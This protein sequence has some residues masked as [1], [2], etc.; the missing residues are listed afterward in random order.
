MDNTEKK[1]S[2]Y[3]QAYVPSKERLAELVTKAKGPERSMAEFSRICKVKS[4]S[5]FSRIVNKLIDKPVSDELLIAIAKNTADSDEVTLDM[6]MRANGKVLKDDNPEYV[7]DPNDRMNIGNHRKGIKLIRDII[8][9][10]Y[11]DEGKSVMLHPDIEIDIDLYKKQPDSK[12]KL[13]FPSHFSLTVQGEET[14]LVNYIIDFTDIHGAS[15]KEFNEHKYNRFYFAENMNK[16][17]PLFLRDAWEPESLRNVKNVIVFTEKKAYQ[18]F[19]E[20]IRDI[21]FNSQISVELITPN[22]LAE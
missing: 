22:T 13:Y 1:V 9:Q 5:T 17:A 3:I 14:L 12:Y 15:I 19:T 10:R 7:P 21:K 6:L 11:L 18:E 8:V 2:E 4:P 20:I 16:Y